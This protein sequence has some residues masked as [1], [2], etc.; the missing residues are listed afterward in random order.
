MNNELWLNYL[1]PGNTKVKTRTEMPPTK[2][3]NG[4]KK[5]SEPKISICGE[6]K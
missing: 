1:E 5:P 2:K 6:Q 3:N 4:T